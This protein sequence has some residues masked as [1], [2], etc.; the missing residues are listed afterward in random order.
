MN[1]PRCQ[2]QN[3]DGVRF[4]EHCGASFAET[5]PKCAAVI[6]PGAAFCGACGV[7]FNAAPADR[8]AS[9]GAYTPSHLAERI[10]T[11]RA[12]LEGERKQVTVLFADLK[13]SMELLADRDP[14]DARHVLDQVLEHMMEAVHRYEGTVNQVMGDGIMALFGAPLAHEDHAVR[15]CYAALRMQETVHRYCE[16]LRRSRGIEVRIRVGLNSGEVV[17]RSIGSDLHMDYTAVGRTTQLAARMEQLASPGTIRLTAE[18]LRLVE[19]Y[20]EVKPLGPIPVKGLTEPVHAFEMID[21]TSVQTRLRARAQ[22]GLTRF[23]GR[24]PE[25]GQLHRALEQARAGHGQI[26]AI[27]GEPGVGKSRLFYEFMHSQGTQDWLVLESTSVSYGRA[28]P[29]LPVIGLLKTYFQIEARDDARTIRERVTGKLLALDRALETALTP[30]QALL[31]ARGEDAQ[32]QALDSSQRRRLTLDAVK[33]FLLRESR[34]QPLILLFDDLHWVD[35]ETQALLDGLVETLPTARILLVAGYRPE[36]QHAWGNKSYYTQLRVDPL[37]EAGAE[38]LLSALLGDEAMLGP[39]KRLLIERTEGNPFFLEES[40][41]TLVETGG[42]SGERGAYGL[43]RDLRT[44]QVPVTIQAVLAARIDRLPAVEKRLLQSAAVVGKDVPLAIL[45]AIADLD[46]ASLRH[47]LAKLQAAEFLYETRLFPDVE[48]AFKHALTHEVAYG[49]LLQNR[50]RALHGRI[51]D[52]LERLYAGRDTEQ[53]E[54]LA[55]HALRGEEWPRAVRYLRQAGARAASRSAHGQAVAYFEQALEIIRHLPEGREAIEQA[56]D[57]RFDLRNSLHPVGDLAPILGH[58]AEAEKL[59]GMLGDQRRLAWV[60]SFMCQY[61]RLVGDLD[62]AIESGHRALAIAEALGDIPLWIAVGTHL[63]PAYGATGD[64]RKATEILTKV[65]DALREN[66][67]REDMGSAGLLSVF[68]RIYLAYYLA[69]RGDFREGMACGEEG[70]RLAVTADHQYS[71]TFAYCGVGTL[72]LVKGD[73]ESAIRLLER[74]LQL[75][76]SLNLP[77]MLPL[78]ASPL[79]S[80]YAL[81][82]RYAEAIP[83]LEEAVSRAV[84][85]ERMG[86]HSILVARLG[87]AYLLAGRLDD[88]GQSARTALELARAQKE[89]GR[90]A[91]ALR[92]A[93]EVA[94][95]GAA[96][97]LDEAEASYRQALA[98]AEELGMRPLLAHCHLGLGRLYRRTRRR[99]D[100][101]QHLAAAIGSF[102]SLDM[103]QWREQAESERR[104]LA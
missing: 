27:V 16:S 13:G 2:A 37:A 53:V 41:R 48:Y 32:W 26:V 43:A 1:C 90:E 30:L 85:M 33:R 84:S 51:V 96:P 55:H 47:S 99:E 14:E 98:L 97:G 9:P 89:R 62:R 92:L 86:E 80:A 10:L 93:G 29:Y 104:S 50:R 91:Y 54:L 52:A 19:G 17:V 38:S 102:R 35:S 15:A 34:T 76:R 22:R 11:S 44:I 8:F 78:L 100:A 4:C 67:G 72:F 5:C 103:P 65:V 28:T 7:A 94:S 73:L 70:I 39:L 61:F 79:G 3:R 31:D 77:L 40:V 68:S 42:L 81:S 74:G 64:F 18:T 71:L 49:G 20:V 12:A 63:G 24:E 23:V 58:L 57:L 21:A 69:E 75:C 87:E 59:A 101:D 56:A 6:A 25:L 88:A 60:F 82:G 66:P 95:R 45:H 83:L 36:Y 46:D